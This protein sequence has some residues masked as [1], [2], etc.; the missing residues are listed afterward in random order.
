MPRPGE[1]GRTNAVPESDWLRSFRWLGIQF[2]LHDTQGQGDCPF[3]GKEGKFWVAY[4]HGKWDCKSCGITG[5]PVDFMRHFHAACFDDTPISACNELASERGFLS[6]STCEAWGCAKSVITGEWLIPA[7]SA[8]GKMHNLYR[9]MDIPNG[10]GGW[11]KTLLPTPGL[12]WKSGD[13]HGLFGQFMILTTL[14][15]ILCEGPWDGMALWEVDRGKHQVFATPGC[16]VF[17][18]KWLPLFQDDQVTLMFDNDHP[19][20]NK[21]TGKMIE[22]SALTGSKRIAAQLA[23]TAKEV[24]W[25]KWGE[26]GWNDQLTD[27]TDVRDLL[28]HSGAGKGVKVSLETKEILFK[29]LEMKVDPVPADWLSSSSSGKAVAGDGKLGL[30]TLACGNW[31]TMVDSLKDALYWRECLDDVTSVMMAVALSTAQ[32]GDQLFLQV[33][34]DPGS[35]KTT[36]CDGMLTSSH[37]FALEHLTGFHSGWKDGSGQS[38]SLLA[39]INGK[40]LITPEGDVL[41]SSPNFNQLMSQQRRIFDGKSGATY[42]NSKEDE[43]FDNLRTPWIMAGTF[44]LLSQDQSRMGDR[45]LKVFVDKAPSNEMQG[46]LDKVAQSAWDAVDVTSN[47]KAGSTTNPKMTKA[48]RLM[49]G[50]VDYLRKD[51]ILRIKA[52]EGDVIEVFRRCKMLAEFTA[53]LRA[54]PDTDVK[55]Q[56]RHDSKELPSRLTHQYV[57]LAKCLAVVLGTYKIDDEVMRRVRKVALNTSAGRTFQMLKHVSACKM[58]GVEVRALSFKSNDKEDRLNTLMDFMASL[59]MVERCG[60]TGLP[61]RKW[62]LTTPMKIL[63]EE[64]VDAKV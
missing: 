7:Y 33:L 51:G 4:E 19:R 63:W 48:H 50:F 54:R 37:C 59:K 12:G 53:C 5:N 14:D 23:G 30:G 58:Q 27:G 45:F 39:R 42:K 15:V 55:K 11:K 6:G 21:L 36:L 9:W 61:F 10:K 41:V 35:A 52:V 31:S 29:A 47:C 49:G 64:A 18:E 60:L 8:D 34:G 44:N 46:I 2:K 20:K 32:K 22:G 38:F 1:T 16:N 28:N 26:K 62:R 25:L 17:N 3:C 40:T 57:R 24:K 43:R 56:D 13:V